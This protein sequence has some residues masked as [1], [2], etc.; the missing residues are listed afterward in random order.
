MANGGYDSEGSLAVSKEV[1]ASPTRT[2]VN[3]SGAKGSCATPTP[4][5]P[6]ICFAV[7]NFEDA[8]DGTVGVVWLSGGEERLEPHRNALSTSSGIS[9]PSVIHLPLRNLGVRPAVLRLPAGIRLMTH[10]TGSSTLPQ[11]LLFGTSAFVN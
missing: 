9:K 11:P 1:Y 2:L 5:Y 4:S 8:F 3:L 7:D 10:P 6:N